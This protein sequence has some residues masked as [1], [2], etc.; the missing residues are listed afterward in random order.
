MR[1]SKIVSVVDAHTEGQP[2]RIVT[3]GFPKILG[4]TMFDKYSYVDR[5][6][7]DMRKLVLYEPRG[8]KTMCGAFLVEPT[9]KDADVG[10]IFIEQIG[11]VPMCGHGSIAIAKLLVETNRV[12]VTEP[13]TKVKL[14]TIGGLVN[15][16][17]GVENG[18][19]G[20]ITLR[21]VKS[22]SYLR[23]VEIKSKRFG[24]INV[25]LAYGGTFYA[26]LSAEDVGLKLIP[27]EAQKMVEYGEI[28]RRI[29]N[30]LGFDASPPRLTL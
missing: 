7:D 18:E 23:G 28:L 11:P 14:D 12:N 29:S 19:V 5:N 6:L 8:S 16:L 25:D 1:V 27:A 22:F 9:V 24:D 2:M 13:I 3:S 10:V 15:L 17:V 4:E 30:N 21:N 26:I 20:E